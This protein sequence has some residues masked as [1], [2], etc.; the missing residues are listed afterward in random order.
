MSARARPPFWRDVARG[1]SPVSLVLLRY[2]ARE[3]FAASALV[4]VAFPACSPSSTSSTSSR[5]WAGRLHA[6]PGPGV[7][8]AHPAGAGV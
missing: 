5:T 3:I 2:L 7:C 8:R 6:L 4:L 1:M